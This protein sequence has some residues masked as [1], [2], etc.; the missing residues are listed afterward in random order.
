MF[1]PAL[2]VKFKLT[3]VVSPVFRLIRVPFWSGVIRRLTFSTVVWLNHT[4][5]IFDSVRTACN[6]T[7]VLVSASGL[8]T[9]TA[10]VYWFPFCE[11][12]ALAVMRGARLCGGYLRQNVE[13]MDVVL[14]PPT[15]GFNPS[16][17]AVG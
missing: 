3:V 17:K 16:K 11:P 1:Q 12:T 8:E 10:A 4:C 6:L 15:V 2:G 9:V 13:Y 5:G 14:L 7:L